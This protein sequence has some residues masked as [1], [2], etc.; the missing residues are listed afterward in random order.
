MHQLCLKRRAE[1]L[2]MSTSQHGAGRQAGRRGLLHTLKELNVNDCK[3]QIAL[4][5]TK[6]LAHKIAPERRATLS[7]LRDNLMASTGDVDAIAYRR[8]GCSVLLDRYS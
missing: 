4:G 5:K 1:R 7:D 8:I 2:V 3:Q 6:R